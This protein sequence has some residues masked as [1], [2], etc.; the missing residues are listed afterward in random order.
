MCSTLNRQSCT[1]AG[2][3]KLTEQDSQIQTRHQS[4]NPF[5]YQS[6]IQNQCLQIRWS[7]SD[8][9]TTNSVDSRYTSYDG[10]G[11]S[12]IV[13]GDR[14]NDTAGIAR[15]RDSGSYSGSRQSGKDRFHC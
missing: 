15:Y 2:A 1:Q 12:A 5:R 8:V 9:G 10:T 6:P 4:L 14:A 7:V 13:Q 11:K 3:D